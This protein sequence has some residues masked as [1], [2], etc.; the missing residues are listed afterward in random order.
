MQYGRYDRFGS[1]VWVTVFIVGSDT[2]RSPIC[3]ITASATPERQASHTNEGLYVK[4]NGRRLHKEL[5]SFDPPKGPEFCSHQKSR[6]SPCDNA[7]IFIK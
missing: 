2:V 5:F 7:V 3:S 4:Q 1:R 6:H